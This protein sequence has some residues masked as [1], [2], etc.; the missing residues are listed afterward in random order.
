M[1]LAGAGVVSNF[2]R[3]AFFAVVLAAAGV[4]ADSAH[5]QQFFNGSQATP[6][7]AINGGGG[8]WNNTTTNWTNDPGTTSSAYDSSALTTTI[9]G[10]SSTS[11]PASGGTVTVAP[12]GVTL[13]G[14]VIFTFTGD[15]TIYTVDG[16]DLRVATGGTTFFVDLVS[17]GTAPSAV[18]NSRITGTEGISV[19]GPGTLVLNGANTYSGGT[20]ICTCATLQLGDAT[21]TASIVGDVFNEGTFN[22]VNA[23][24]TGITSITNDG[25]FNPFAATN[26]LNN[27]SASNIQITNFNGGITNFGDTSG[28]VHTATA[29]NATI[30]NDGGATFF[31]S[32]TTAG[33]AKITNQ[34]GG[35]TGFADQSSAGSATIINENFGATDFGQ[36]FSLTDRP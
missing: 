4:C 6:N 12:G 24:T 7:G 5:G 14:A 22:I 17:G 20:T 25:T 35:F 36:P 11:T 33:S 19:I 34:F 27:T 32:Q 15:N 8:V 29:G 3:A 2:V 18:I 23:N 30:L 10:A 16:G 13:T 28:A 9:F 1:R 21:H 31:F 26:F